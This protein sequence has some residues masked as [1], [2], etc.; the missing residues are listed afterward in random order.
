MRAFTIVLALWAAALCTTPASASSWLC[1]QP[2]P[3]CLKIDYSPRA[4]TAYNDCGH[5]VGIGVTVVDGLGSGIMELTKP[6]GQLSIGPP[7]D[8]EKGKGK[9]AYYDDTFVCC[10]NTRKPEYECGG[11]R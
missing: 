4:I 10:L 5:L 1:T 8:T 3:S 7:Y 11:E 6:Y 2:V 9:N